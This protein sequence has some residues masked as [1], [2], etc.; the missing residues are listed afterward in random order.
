MLAK[1]VVLV[2]LVVLVWKAYQWGA[3]A[4]RRRMATQ[5]TGPTPTHNTRNAGPRAPEPVTEDL[6]ACPICGAYIARASAP[7]G[8]PECPQRR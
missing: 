6:R 1:L 8:K 4:Q 2:G 7:C 5:A 3:A